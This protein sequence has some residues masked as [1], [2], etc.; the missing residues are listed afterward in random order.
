MSLASA[1][2]A[3]IIGYNVR[4]QGKATQ[5]ADAEAVMAALRSDNALD[6]LGASYIGL[7]LNRR[8]LDRALDA[9]VDEVN[10]AFKA[11][12]GGVL[13]ADWRAHAEAI[14]RDFIARRLSPGGSADLLG[15][16]LFLAELDGLA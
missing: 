11:A 4:A 14:D 1:S 6:S 12:A 3:V 2:D 5:M 16:T 7:V 15:I 9:G 8:G 13:A 10:A